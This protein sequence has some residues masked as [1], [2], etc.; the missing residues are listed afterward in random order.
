M[1]IL[2]KSFDRFWHGPFIG[3]YDPSAAKQKYTYAASSINDAASHDRR[4]ARGDIV[5]ALGEALAEVGPTIFAAAVSEVL[6]FTVGATTNIPAL[7]QFCVVAAVAVAIDFFLQ[8]GWFCAAIILDARRQAGYRLDLLP[9]LKMAWPQPPQVQDEFDTLSSSLLS[10]SDRVTGAPTEQSPTLYARI[11][12]RVYRGA[13]VREFF[14]KYYA[15]FLLWTPVRILV[16]F[17]WAGFLGASLYGATQLKLGLEQQLVLPTDSYLTTYFDDQSMY[18]EAGPPLY[19]VLQN[20]NYTAP[21]FAT[22]VQNLVTD[23][24][25]VQRWIDPPISSWVSNFAYWNSDVSR[26]SIAGN[27]IWGCPV[28]LEPGTVSYAMQVAQFLYDIPITSSC[29][30]SADYC[31]AQYSSDVKLLWGWPANASQPAPNGTDYGGCDMD[32]GY[33]SHA[34]VEQALE[35]EGKTLQSRV[36]VGHAGLTALPS[37]V[38]A[39]M[40]K[41]LSKKTGFTVGSSA[42]E[43]LRTHGETLGREPCGGGNCTVELVPCHVFTS[44]LRTQLVA[45]RNQS[46]FVGAMQHVQAAVQNLQ[47]NLPAADLTQYGITTV[48]DQF[49]ISGTFTYGFESDNE[50]T[51]W[52]DAAPGGNAFPY[53]LTFV[54]YEQVSSVVYDCCLCSLL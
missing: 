12:A 8:L 9:F 16:L 42:A 23:L 41:A 37:H 49:G 31:S 53:S 7:K 5:F 40:S 25:G 18:G 29:C 15:P 2:T 34:D 24:T 39:Q 38:L 13:Y 30:Q 45:L 54:Y 35:A 22:T 44:R 28:P 36:S 21:G 48:S 19:V 10:T 4:E 6:A 1:F 52:L 51:M 47:S 3:R 50:H 32:L 20:V 43:V 46:D 33:I 11:K 27:P 26:N 14:D 17:V